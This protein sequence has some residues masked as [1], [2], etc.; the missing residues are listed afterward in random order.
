MYVF[1]AGGMGVTPFRSIIK[2]HLEKK[3]KLDAT[4]LYFASS[5]SELLFQDIFTD[6]VAQIGITFIPVLSD[7]SAADWHG[8]TGRFSEEF[9]K[10]HVSNIQ[11]PSYY[12]AGSHSFINAT[13]EI[14]QSLGI[15][16]EQIKTDPFSGY[17]T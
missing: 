5:Q 11:Q 1:I 2:Q 12:I 9:L 10:K 7:V 8:A 13:M 15:A 17:L 3:Q 14:L 6:A 16:D 4:L